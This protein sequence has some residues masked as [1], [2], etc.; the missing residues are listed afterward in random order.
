MELS[1]RWLVPKDLVS[2]EDEGMIYAATDFDTF[3][4][5]PGVYIFARR[6]GDTIEPLYVGK[7][8][9]I[10]KRI[11]QQLNNVKLMKSVEIAKNGQRVVLIGVFEKKPNQDIDKALKIIESALIEHCL[12][13][14]YD[15]LNHQGTK[16]PVHNL[17]FSGNRDSTCLTGTVIK[18]PKRV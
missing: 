14:G 15:I 17:Q 5:D 2:A 1:I 12:S 13:W 18:V 4:A 11:A 7:A 16:R 6:Y 9:N 3:P 8:K 10:K